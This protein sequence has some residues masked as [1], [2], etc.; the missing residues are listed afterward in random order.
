MPQPPRTVL[1]AIRILRGRSQRDLASDLKISQSAVSH[2][3]SGTQR[4]DAD[5]ASRIA[6]ALGMRQ[7]L[8]YRPSPAPRI[9]HLLMTSLPRTARNRAFAE[10]TLAH[11]HVDLLLDPVDADLERDH[12]HARDDPDEFAVALRARWGMPA[13]PVSELIRVVEAHGIICVYRDLSSL[14]V[15]AIASSS[16]TGRTLLFLDVGHARVELA[17]AIAHELAHLCIDSGPSSPE[18]RR[19]TAFASSFLMPAT[20]LL[21]DG[22]VRS[23]IDLAAAASRWGVRPRALAQRLRDVRMVSH[24]QF[25]ELVHAAQGHAHDDTHT[26]LLGSPSTLARAVRQSGSS[27]AAADRALLEQDELRLGYLVRSAT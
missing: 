1:E 13:G 27:R 26:Q 25:R 20:D 4:A 8:L 14:G 10:V 12:D 23:D 16:L 2:L 17:E 3:E 11:A 5:L 18:E 19:A 9:R 6:A 22:D 15:A 21:A 24:R 7:E